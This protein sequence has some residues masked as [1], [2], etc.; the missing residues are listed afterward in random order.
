MTPAQEA[1]LGRF[2][3]LLREAPLNLL[4]RR[5]RE[6]VW[7]RHVGESVK[8]SEQLTLESGEHWLDIGTGGGLPGLVLAILYPALRF[9]LLDARGKKIAAVRGFIEALALANV[10]AVVGRAEA[11]AWEAA[12]RAQ[13]D[14]VISRAVGR[15]TT[16][17]ELS[18][19]FARPGGQIVAIRG[20]RVGEELQSLRSTMDLLAVRDVQIAPIPGAARQTRLVKMRA[21]GDP[22]A[23]IPRPDGVP[24]ARPLGRGSA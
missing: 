24:A 2:A 8:V 7:E 23:G 16:V 22:P 14:G 3:E 20:G 9:T 17:V 1:E 21:Q 4:S 13:F 15:L 12:W 6:L 19:G 10:E 5:D 11:L 18:R